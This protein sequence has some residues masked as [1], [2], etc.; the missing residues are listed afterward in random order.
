MNKTK[1]IIKWILPVGALFGAIWI[2]MALYDAA[3]ESNPFFTTSSPEGTY[4]VKLTGQKQRPFFFTNTVNYQVL[5][6]GQPFLPSTYIHSGDAMDISFELAYPN[7]RW[8]SE[9]ILHLYR[10]EYFNYGKPDTLVVVNRTGQVIKHLKVASEDQFLF[11]DLQPGA[12]IKLLNS[13]SRGDY[14]WFKAVGELYDGRKIKSGENL[15]PNKELSG[16]STYYIYINTD[17]AIFEGPK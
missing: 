10:E 9:N 5:K 6:N 1:T 7:H 16:P 15:K 8:L 3:V 12:E 2:S 11:F 13:R 14:K 17:S 4:T